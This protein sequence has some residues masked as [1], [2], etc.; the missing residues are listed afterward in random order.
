MKKNQ[1]DRHRASSGKIM[2]DESVVSEY[3]A[4]VGAE[5]LDPTRYTVVHL[6]NSDIRPRIHEELNK[7]LL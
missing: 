3:L 2:I 6:D 4:V 1:Q 7:R 5:K